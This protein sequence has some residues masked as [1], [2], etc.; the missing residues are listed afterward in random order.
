MDVGT[1]YHKPYVLEINFFPKQILRPQG[2]QCT[3]EAVKTEFCRLYATV[4]SIYHLSFINTYEANSSLLIL[5]PSCQER[6]QKQGRKLHNVCAM[7][8]M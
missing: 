1:M 8:A 6:N 7:G 4:G 3:S 2:Q 5:F